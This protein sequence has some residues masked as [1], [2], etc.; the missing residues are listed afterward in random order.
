MLKKNWKRLSM[1]AGLSLTL[2]AAG[3]GSSDSD[4]EN[5]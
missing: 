5:T 1:A 3:C 2:F 4:E